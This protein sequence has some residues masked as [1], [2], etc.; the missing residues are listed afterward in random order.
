VPA[1]E[2]GCD[3]PD[4]VADVVMDLSRQLAGAEARYR[5]A[6]TVLLWARRG[7]STDAK[8]QA[9]IARIRPDLEAMR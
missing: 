2:H 5:D 1:H 3:W 4:A 8:A 7:L 9:A 6:L